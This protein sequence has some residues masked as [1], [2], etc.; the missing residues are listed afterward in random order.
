MALKTTFALML[1][2]LTDAVNDESFVAKNSILRDNV[3]KTELLAR[4]AALRP[5]YDLELTHLDVTA[6]NIIGTVI[7]LDNVN[8]ELD[9]STDALGAEERAIFNGLPAAA[10]PPLRVK[11]W[12]LSSD[13][14]LLPAD[15]E[16]HY[17]IPDLN[18]ADP[19]KKLLQVDDVQLLAG[20]QFS[21]VVP[22]QLGQARVLKKLHILA[23][24]I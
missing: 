6:A 15:I 8:R 2:V 13:S 12:L 4:V 3:T 1:Q 7:T 11:G 9:F 24:Q 14:T 23:E 17:R 22:V 10:T 5:V 18:P 20:A 21:V 19:W 16:V